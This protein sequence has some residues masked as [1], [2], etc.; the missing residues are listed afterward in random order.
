MLPLLRATPRVWGRAGIAPTTPWPRM[1]LPT[2][3]KLCYASTGMITRTRL[4]ALLIV[5]AVS[6]SAGCGRTNSGSYKIALVPSTRTGHGIFVM[7]SDTSG[8]KLLTPDVNAQLRLGSWSPDGS[9]I[10]FL[11]TRPDDAE[12]VIT[13]PHHLPLYVMDSGGGH[14]K[15]LVDVPVTDFGWS[16]DGRKMFFISAF[17]DPAHTDPEVLRGARTPLSA[18]YVVD[19]ATGEQKRLT[20]FGR[21]TSASWSP[22]GSRMVLSL[23]GDDQNSDIYVT[24]VDGSHARR[25]T[26][27]LN[28]DIR[29]SWSLDGQRIAYISMGEPG[30]A[31]PDAGI[32]VIK[33][34]GS[35]KRRLTDLA[36]YAA[37]WSPDSKSLLM[38]AQGAIYL[39]E[40]DSGKLF[41]LPVR[42]DSP[43]DAVFAPDGQN[44][45]FR[46]NHEGD[47][48]LYVIDTTGKNVHRATDL[49][50]FMFCLSPRL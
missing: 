18:I 8:G 37:S 26:D 21:N 41:K 5:V 7:N 16:P 25:L 20:S 35:G 2:A 42:T 1:A 4:T 30:V 29:P 6:I 10:A 3:E 40:V 47:W 22:D 12:V 46:S 28:Q 33:P 19:V 14:S 34:D 27:S 9:R 23:A 13:I 38:Q 11:T 31:A 49:T 15:R 43:L 36:I 24:S 48:Y 44:V 50:A 45:I 17:E 32:Y 39:V